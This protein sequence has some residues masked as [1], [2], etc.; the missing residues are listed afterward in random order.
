R[1]G[2][3]SGGFD[4]GVMRGD[5][6][7]AIAELAAD[8]AMLAHTLYRSQVPVVVACTGHAIATGA[9]VLLGCDLRS[10]AD[11][12]VKIGMSEHAIGMS[13]PDW[14][15]TI[16]TERLS[17]TMLQR[18]VMNAELYGPRDAVAVGY[19]D[20]VVAAEQVLDRAVE[21]ADQLG[22]QI[23][24]RARASTLQ[25]LRG[26]MLATLAEQAAAFRDGGVL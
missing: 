2:R 15:L 10:G 22:G 13:L 5:D 25:R 14:A 7:A 18:S 9:M 17:A 16:L 19:L 26:P 20:E 21:A 11:P 1:D 8:G 23:D 24:L 6:V 12:D 3:F 4:L